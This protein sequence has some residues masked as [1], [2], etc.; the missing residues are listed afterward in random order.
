MKLISLKLGNLIHSFKVA[1]SKHHIRYL[2]A[3]DKSI[4]E[5]IQFP[6]LFHSTKFAAEQQTE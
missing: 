6:E 4:V 3:K 5:K 1:V 2:T